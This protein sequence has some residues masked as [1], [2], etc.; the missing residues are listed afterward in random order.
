[1]SALAKAAHLR[2]KANGIRA[3]LGG[4]AVRGGR[5]KRVFDLAFA[6]ILLISIAPTLLV[7]AIAIKMDSPGPIFY[8]QRRLGRDNGSF[9]LIKFRSMYAGANRGTRISANEGQEEVMFKIRRDPRVTRIGRFLRRSSLDELPQLLNVIR[10]DMSLVGPRPSVHEEEVPQDEDAEV[11]RSAVRPGL[12]GIARLVQLSR[13]RYLTYEEEANLEAEYARS[14]SLFSDLRLLLRS[15]HY[16][17]SR[18]D[19]R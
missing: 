13:G 9:A 7:I 1:M 4:V 3:S 14:A 19:L 16:A 12:V 18:R 6:S 2:W 8:R 11:A 15:V 17:L 10:G 5:I